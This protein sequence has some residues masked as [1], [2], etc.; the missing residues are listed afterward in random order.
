MISVAPAGRPLGSRGRRELNKWNGI[1]LCQWYVLS[2]CQWHPGGHTAWFTSS[3]LPVMAPIKLNR[4]VNGPAN[5]H[6][7]PGEDQAGSGL[8][9]EADPPVSLCRMNRR[10]SSL[11]PQT[12]LL[13]RKTFIAS[14][15]IFPR[16]LPIRQAKL[17]S[18]CMHELGF[19]SNW[20]LNVCHVIRVLFRCAVFSQAVGGNDSSSKGSAP[21]KTIN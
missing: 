4:W 5:G 20:S 11:S 15:L 8:R 7:Y 21:L 2:W 10:H 6:Q 1:R 17:L 16:S 18:F 14:F 13:F 3:S 9:S 12:V 19:L